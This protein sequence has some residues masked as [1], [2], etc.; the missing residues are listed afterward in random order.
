MEKTFQGKLGTYIVRETEDKSLTIWSGFFDENCHSLAGAI[1]ETI[2]NY[3]EGAEVLP[4]LTEGRPCSVFEVGFGA[5]IGPKLTI[6]KWRELGAKAPLSFIS[7][8]LDPALVEFVRDNSEED[9]LK[10]LVR[11]ENGHFV[12]KEGLLK[13]KIL[14]GDARK[15]IKEFQKENHLIDSF[16]QDAFSPKKN[17]A[18][19]T[20]EWFKDLKIIAK[21]QAVL[22]TYSCSNAIRKSLVQ[23]GW[24]VFNR[25]GFG[26]KRH[27]TIAK[28][29]GESSDEILLSLSRSPVVALVDQ[30]L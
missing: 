13:F 12:F 16:Y 7:T 29:Q 11:D 22:S 19:W 20:V 27:A 28:S 3:L 8:E 21:D 24:A 30:K 17:P 14:I 1:N 2:Y 25:K 9:F 26:T 4:K 15:T 10:N 23:A 6:N 18:L 5:G